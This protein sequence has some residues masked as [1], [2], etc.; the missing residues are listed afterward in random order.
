MRRRSL[1]RRLLLG[2]LV[3]V[4]VGAAALFATARLL[5]PELFQA[6]LD[7]I[8][9][10]YGW[11]TEG[12]TPAG[13]GPGSGQGGQQAAL[14]SD[15]DQAFT[16]SLTVA[17][18]VALGAGALAA[19]TGAA[20]VSRRLLRPLNGMRVAVGHMAEGHY[21]ERVPV[22]DDRELADLADD[23]NALGGALKETEQRRARL[24]SDLAHELRTPIASL[25]G[26]VEGLEDGVFQ[27]DPETLGA[28]RGETRRLLRLASDLGVLSRTDEHA[29]DLH[30]EEADLGALAA[31][32]A[33]AL[34]AAFTA[35]GLTVNVVPGPELPV[36][37]DPDRMAQ[38]FSNLLRNALQHTPSGGSVTLGGRRQGSFVE[39]V[40][41][42]TGEGIGP[43]HLGRVFDRFFRV[44]AA[45]PAS[46]GAGIGLTI[47]RGI[48]RAHGGELTAASPGLGEGAAFTVT[49][50]LRA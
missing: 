34:G 13:G 35:G 45:S 46:G 39:V 19:V 17:L 18:G 47:A 30:L 44:D 16:T 33:R 14:E 22:P 23:V 21:D 25:D 1:Y 3:V 12:T 27:A 32:A 38:V 49:L 29:F 7:S 24:V 48:C 8:G 41:A 20:L 36:R 2:N 43:E 10:H 6:R 37:A 42:D 4:A 28:M 9:Q 40:V 15:L 50:P 26:F 5:G 11:R 31:Q